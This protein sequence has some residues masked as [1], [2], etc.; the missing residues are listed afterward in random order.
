LEQ[1][2]G[3]NK[4]VLEINQIKN[5]IARFG[6]LSFPPITPEGW[7]ELSKVLQRRCL[8]MDQVE[9]V[10]DRWLDTGADVPKPAQLN[11]LAREMF[12]PKTDLTAPVLEY[13]EAVIRGLIAAPCPACNG[14]G[15]VGQPPN[16]E[17]C[18]A[19]VVG[20]HE[21]KWNGAAGLERVNEPPGPPRPAPRE[22]WLRHFTPITPEQMAEAVRDEQRRRETQVASV[23][24]Q[25]DGLPRFELEDEEEDNP[26]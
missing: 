19:C 24:E 2:E 23:E 25:E 13:S 10:V 4:A 1:A 15:Y 7:L 22:G 3:R 20:R 6:G 14:A 8:T 11:A 12:D 16:A 18:T 9:R 26:A 17:Y 5:Q 21:Q